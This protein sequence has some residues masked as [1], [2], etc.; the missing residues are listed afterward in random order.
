MHGDRE[1]QSAAVEQ[2]ACSW[3]EVDETG[4]PGAEPVE[5][6]PEAVPVSQ[7]A[8]NM[9]RGFVGAVQAV[10][11]FLDQ[12]V[13]MPEEAADDAEERI[14]PLIAKRGWDAPGG[15]SRYGEEV[16]AGF[17]A[18]ALLAT[19]YRQLAQLRAQDAQAKRDHKTERSRP[20]EHAATG[21]VR[22]TEPEP[23]PV[24]DDEVGGWEQGGRL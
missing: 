3:E 14:A 23:Q 22:P 24:A 6:L 16:S 17:C 18:G 11:R 21:P 4:Q 15:G 20:T 9:A 5:E 8:R 12:R 1:Q 13:T 2:L 10:F 7:G 19:G